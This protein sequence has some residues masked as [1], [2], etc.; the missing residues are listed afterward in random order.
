MAWILLLPALGL[1]LISPVIQP[2]QLQE[3]ETKLALS[4]PAFGSPANGSG[5]PAH[6]GHKAR[7]SAS[8]SRPA[9]TK[10][11]FTFLGPQPIVS[12][13]P[14][15][16]NLIQTIKQPDIFKAPKLR[17][18]IQA[19]N[20]LQIAAPAP[21]LAPQTK[22]VELA[23]ANMGVHIPV[24]TQASQPTPNAKL[25]L[26]MS[27]DLATKSVN[28]LMT[29]TANAP[30][31]AEVPPAPPPVSGEGSDRR[32]LLV[33]NAMPTV[34][35]PPQIPAGELTG[36]FAVSPE[37]NPGANAG[38]V[39]T[40]APGAG[41]RGSSTGAGSGKSPGS[42][43]GTGSSD[44]GT[45]AGG[46]GAV[47]GN[48]P[49][50]GTEHGGLGGNGLGKGADSGPAGRG[51]GSVGLNGSGGPGNSSFP[52]LSIGSAPPAISATGAPPHAPI[53]RGT[54]AM[55]IVAT[56]G[57]GGGLGD[58][59]IFKNEIVY[60]VYIDVDEPD[61]ARPKW[62]LQYSGMAPSSNAQIVAPFPTA[63]DYPHLPAQAT[64]RN[65]GRKLV[66]TGV[67]TKEGKPENLRVI[68]SPNPLLIQPLLD[69]LAKWTFQ[70]A[71]S[72]GE[73]LPVKFV[74]GIPITAELLNAN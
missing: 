64:G 40:A 43:P 29:A 53:P 23:K 37:G 12:E 15:H 8:D 17:A 32:N 42:G 19:P 20:I 67:I 49:G 68:Q 50:S 61:H 44:G 30:Q 47:A 56:S 51:S 73:P 65:I 35:P 45:S 27:G 70:A 31:L 1:L 13:L 22:I 54:Y 7:G 16:D 34:G 4:L 18:P 33:L 26:P 36:S 14:H 63:K 74:L 3:K 41:V 38:T 71:E 72:N 59:G 62:T 21:V 55:T 57:S 11:G 6:A 48:G 39:S 24:K 10:T 9:S 60:T 66:V 5:H 58:Y 2:A 46:G 52:G 25:T 69:C 28:S